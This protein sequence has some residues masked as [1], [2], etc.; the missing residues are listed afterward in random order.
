[1]L[2]KTRQLYLQK[3][4]TKMRNPIAVECQAVIFLYYISDDGRY[5][6]TKNAF[7]VSRSSFSILIRKVAKT[8][9]IY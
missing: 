8:I 9:I 2:N 4:Q 5:S 7:R 1:M 3:Q 6:K